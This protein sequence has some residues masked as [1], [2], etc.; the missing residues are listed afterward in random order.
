MLL[1][2]LGLLVSGD[3]VLFLLGLALLFQLREI[4]FELLLPF[5]ALFLFLFA[6]QGVLFVLQGLG[7]IV[8]DTLNIFILIQRRQQSDQVF[9]V[10]GAAS[11]Y[12]D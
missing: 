5:L 4:F 6:L 9:I 1:F 11:G 10:A 8:L 7:L 2:L 3:L 12:W